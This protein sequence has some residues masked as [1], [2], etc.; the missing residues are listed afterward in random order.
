[1]HRV[2]LA[3]RYYCICSMQ[4]PFFAQL[5]TALTVLVSCVVSMLA[6]F[7]R[8]QSNTCAVNEGKGGMLQAHVN[9]AGRTAAPTAAAALITRN[10]V[11][12]S[13]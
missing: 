7:R 4:L 13:T 12:L 11:G 8:L 2:T 6:V 3:D 1:M 9:V 10:V 5:G